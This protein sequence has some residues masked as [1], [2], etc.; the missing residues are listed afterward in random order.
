MG[1]GE[2]LIIVAVWISIGLVT[3]LWMARRGHDWKWTLFAVGLGPL[4]VPIAWERV[5]RHPRVAASG[6]DGPPGPRSGTPGPRVMVGIDGSTEAEQ[7][8]DVARSLFGPRCE[9]LL[10][11]EV[12]SYDDT[13]PDSPQAIESATAHLAS[14]AARAAGLPLNQEVLAGPAGPTLR[15]YASDH[16]MDV[17]VVGRRGRGLAETLLGS[18]SADLLHHSEVPVLVVEPRRAPAAS[19]QAADASSRVP[20]Q[21]AP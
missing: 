15:Q 18:V 9:L 6:A 10:L 19:S 1:T 5:E 20:E 12:V 21:P 2:V 13:E 17:L 8:L 16:D 11:A 7:A 14:A 4:F 3:G